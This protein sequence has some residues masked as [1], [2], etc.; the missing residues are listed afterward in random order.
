MLVGGGYTISHLAHKVFS[1]HGTILGRSMPCMPVNRP[2]SIALAAV[3]DSN[4][5]NPPGV[6][7]AEGASATAYWPGKAAVVIVAPAMVVDVAVRVGA[8]GGVVV[9]LPPL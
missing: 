1:F 8:G 3:L 9:Q 5:L 2:L 6:G 4:E 7:I